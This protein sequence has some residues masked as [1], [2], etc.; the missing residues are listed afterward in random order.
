MNLPARD[1][2]IPNRHHLLRYCRPKQLENGK[3]TM[4]A[5]LLRPGEEFLSVD[6]LEYFGEDITA[7]EQVKKARE[8]IGKTLRLSAGGRFARVKVGAVKSQVE[9]AEVK[10]SPSPK[11]PSHAG[12]Y[13]PENNAQESA[14]ALA[15]LI[16]PGDV[17]PGKA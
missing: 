14:F 16:T 13:L 6:W 5:F 11:N 15:N 1:A 9:R 12:I 2:A 7:S 4:A 17:F 8:G 3:V 10:H